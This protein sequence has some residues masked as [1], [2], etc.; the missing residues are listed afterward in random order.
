MIKEI[1]TSLLILGSSLS[2]TI[3]TQQVF[4]QLDIDESSQWTQQIE[5]Y[6]DT[7]E[8]I[9][10]YRTREARKVITGSFEITTR[11]LEYY[12][13]DTTAVNEKAITTIWILSYYECKNTT[14]TDLT[15][16]QYGTYN[17]MYPV[18]NNS[19]WFQTGLQNVRTNPTIN[20]FFNLTNYTTI[21]DYET[22][23]N[24]IDTVYN[25]QIQ[26]TPGTTMQEMAT[27]QYTW[28]EDSTL[29]TNWSMLNK[30]V[31][32]YD[33][34][35]LMPIAP[36]ETYRTMPYIQYWHITFDADTSNAGE[37][38]D[39]P[40][41]MFTILGMPFAWLSQAFNLTI[42]P[43]T[44]YA[45]NIARLMIVIISSLMLLIIIK[46]LIK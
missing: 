27:W 45:I 36:I 14:L 5:N 40:G 31:I 32:V 7:P 43:G 20:S 11:V 39:I 13:N 19:M 30:Y 42:F 9:K 10:A 15:I 8:S 4:K 17:T 12:Y 6:N 44:P 18:V 26:Y 2:N 3:I 41:L 24:A 35:I 22:L 38:V 33:D 1:T 16:A 23:R 28:L 29:T 34:E 37:I 25:Q 46:K 21:E